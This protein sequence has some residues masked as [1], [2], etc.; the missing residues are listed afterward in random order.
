[1]K[2]SRR[3]HA[4]AF[5]IVEVTVAIG[6]FGITAAAAI[7]AMIRMN[8]NAALCRLQTG[9][10]TVAQNQIDLILSDAPFNPQYSQVPPELTPGTTSTGTS[11]A[12][13]VAVYT[14]PSSGAKV[15]GWMTTVVTD[16]SSA[17]NGN[18]LYVYRATVTVSYFYKGRQYNVSMCTMR[19]ADT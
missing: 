5:T 3:F 6:L 17:L 7:G 18:T 1:M 15:L 14:D 2:S 16:T 4:A 11:S 19:C 13:T 9:A 8:T 10:S 12:P